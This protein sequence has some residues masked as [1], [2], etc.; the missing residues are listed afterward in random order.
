M[1]VIQVPVPLI[2]QISNQFLD[3]LKGISAF[4]GLFRENTDR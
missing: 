1:G 3:D 4:K 2:G